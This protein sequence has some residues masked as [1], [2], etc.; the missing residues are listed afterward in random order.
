MW[1]EKK[2][3]ADQRCKK[4]KAGKKQEWIEESELR[5]C[6]KIRGKLY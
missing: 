4:R 2:V 3:K 5:G 1:G 6:K